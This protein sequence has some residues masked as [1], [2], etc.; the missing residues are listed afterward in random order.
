MEYT[1]SH[2]SKVLVANRGEIAVRLIKACKKVGLKSVSI[3]T[4]SDATSLHASLADENILLPGENANGYLDT[5]EIL[6][7]C[8]RLNV[9]AIIPGYGFLSED[10]SFAQKVVDAGMVFVGPSSESMTEMGQKHRA[11]DLA[12]SAEVP[13]VPGTKLL[14]SQDAALEASKKLGFPIM[15]KATGGGGGMGLQVCHNEEEIATAFNK[16]KSRGETLFNNAGVFLEKYYPQSRHIEVQIFGN[17]TDVVH[18]GERECSI[19]RRHQKV[20][21]ECPSAF[22]QKRP[23]MRE[24]LTKCATAYALQLKY[25]SAGTIEFLVDD[26]TGDFFFLEMNTRLQ[27]EHGI[28]ELCYEV[29]LVALMLQ[30]ADCEKGGKKGL[31]SEFL[32]SLQ[33]DVPTGAAIEARVYAEVPYRNY[34]PSPGLLQAVQWPEGEG[35][36]IDTWVKTGQRIASF[37]DPLIAK[38]MVH[39][40]DRQSACTKMAKVLS[41]STLQG[42]PTNIHFL[43]DVISSKPFSDGETLTNFLETKFS[44]E[45]HAIDVLSP[46]SFTTVQDFPARA[47]SGHGIPK[48]GPMDNLSSRVANVLVGNKPG[49]EVL[50]MTLTGPELLFTAP[51]V[52]AVCGAP[53]SVTVD[54]EEKS[55]WSRLTIQAG[56]KLKIGKIENGGLRFYLAVKGGFPEI[57]L[58]LGSKA[59]TPSLG[60]GGTQGR[61]LQMGDWIEL[62][63][64]TKDWAETTDLFTLPK[65]CIPDFDI[66]DIYCMHGPHDSDDFMTE[67]DKRMLYSTAWKIGHNSN[68]TGI[69]LVG[70]VPEWSRKDGGEGGSHPSNIF[71]YGYPSPGG[72]N[73]GGDSSVIFSMDSPDLGGLLCSS[74]VISADLWRLGQVKP[75]GYLKLRPTSFELALELTSRVEKFIQDMQAFVDGQSKTVPKLDLTLPNSG[76]EEGKSDAILRKFPA[77]N[78]RHQ[79]VYR[80]GGDSFLLVEIGTQTV[81]VRVTTRIRLLVEKLQKLKN[82]K[83]VMNP[84]VGSV[85]IQ[86][87]PKSITQNDLLNLVHDAESS[88]QA[89]VDIKIPCREIYVPVVFDHPDIAASEKRYIETN[90]PTAVY[91]PDNVEYL[92]TNNGLSTRRETFETLLKSPYLIV[93]V[94]FLVG[95]PILFPLEPMSGIVGQKYNPTRVSTP[96]GTIGMGGSLFAIYPVEAPGGYMM[97]AR[98][99]ECWDSFGS[100]PSFSPTRPWLYEPFDIVRY[101]EVSV[102]EYD[103]LM[104]D[105]KRG[106]YKFDIRDGVFDLAEIYSVFEN[107]K[108]D[109]GVKEF[110]ERQ[111]KAVV[112]NLAIEKRL[113]GEWVAAQEAEKEKEAERVKEMMNAEPSITI[114][115]PIDANVWK[116]LVEPGDVLEEGQV[117]AIL[118]AMKME[119]NVLCEGEAVGKKVEAIASKPGSVVQPGAWI[120]VVKAE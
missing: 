99:M 46:G 105:Y 54:G 51:A 85:M 56:Q 59:G 96:G 13:V 114:N 115:S 98:T 88:I 31:S 77:D 90:R 7:I 19:Q 57:P 47:T 8:Q 14:D 79:V 34:A 44:Y 2:L 64:E 25:K 17:G 5:A 78:E 75:G 72:I 4:D 23:G 20:I 55:M 33:K 66:S 53:V 10:A 1:F 116:V 73:W 62:H 108:S 95:T 92:R 86:F 29:D 6:N 35:I 22:V 68:R 70:P 24:K 3:Y 118:E 117:V 111:R 82:P 43:A 104:L 84:N 40:S 52:Y 38:I 21:E 37:Y 107:S 30:Q 81:D 97:F 18:F 39:A 94:G 65:A 32:H 71:D 45:P 103:N 50:E 69:R 91:L 61:Q 48:G 67:K 100:G 27:V 11:R 120:V 63:R 110:R 113:Y 93:A 102:K 83:L 74:T 76:L 26:E 12:V 87:D 109:R 42:P 112:E 9:E 41:E 80:Q 15:L 101:H 119:I 60:F 28:T 89:T 58:Y 36:R 16:V 106:N 49:M